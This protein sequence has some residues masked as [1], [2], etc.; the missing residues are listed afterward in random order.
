VLGFKVDFETTIDEADMKKRFLP[1]FYREQNPKWSDENIRDKIANMTQEDMDDAVKASFYDENPD[2]IKLVVSDIFA[3]WRNRSN[4]GKIQRPVHHTC[5]W[6][7]GKY[8]DGIDV[9][10]R[11]PAR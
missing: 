7:Q 3:Y 11:V 10:Q 6:R 1:Q 4:E 2:H 8:P 5:R 9:F